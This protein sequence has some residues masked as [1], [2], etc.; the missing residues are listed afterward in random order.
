MTI[1]YNVGHNDKK[2]KAG[3]YTAYAGFSE[4]PHKGADNKFYKKGED[5]L[6][7]VSST[8][9]G[10]YNKLTTKVWY[11]SENMKIPSIETIGLNLAGYCASDIDTWKEI[12]PLKK[13]SELLCLSD[14]ANA[15]SFQVNAVKNL[16]KK[17]NKAMTVEANWE[18]NRYNLT[19]NYNYATTKPTGGATTIAKDGNSATWVGFFTYDGKIK[20]VFN[21]DKIKRNG[22]IF[23]GWYIGNTQFWNVNGEPT[24]PLNYNNKPW[25]DKNG[26]YKW[27]GNTNV[28]AKWTPIEWT[29]KYDANGGTGTMADSKHTY[30]DTTKKLSKCTFTK[31]GH[32]FE[33]WYASRARK[34]ANGNVVK[35]N[36][37]IVYEWLYC[38]KE[39]KY[40]NGANWFTEAEGTEKGYKKF[41]FT[42]EHTCSTITYRSNDVITMHAHWK[43]NT[44]TVK[45]NANGGTGTM[46]DS[47]HTYGDATKTLRKC[48]FTRK[49]YTFNGYWYA[50]RARRDANGNVVKANGKT[51]YEWLYGNKEGKY[52]NGANWFTA[53]EGTKNG[54]K[55]FKF[56]DGGTCSV[57][58]YRANDVI[59]MHAQWTP[60]KYNLTLYYNNATTKPTGGATTIAKDGKSATW[61]DYFTYDAKI[62][63]IFG[64][65]KIERTGY[66]F[67]GW[68]IGGKENGTKFWDAAGNP[69]VPLDYKEKP[70]SDKD[71]NYKWDGNT[72]VT[73]EWTENSYTIKFDGNKPGTAS[74]EVTKI[75][76]SKKVKY[77]E[78]VTLNEKSS[79]TGWTFTGWNTEA[80]GSG[81]GYKYNDVVSKLSATNNA[82]VTLY[83]QWEENSYNIVFHGNTPVKP[84]A[85]SSNVTGTVASMKNVKYETIFNLPK[86]TGTKSAF[87][88]TGWKF[89]GW[90]R[91]DTDKNGNNNGLSIDY[92]DGAE[93]QGLSATNGATVN[94][95]A[96]WD[97]NK[98]RI[99]LEKMAGE[100]GTDF[101]Y[102]KYD[103]GFYS[104][105]NCKNKIEGKKIKV[106]SRVNYKFNGYFTEKNSAGTAVIDTDGNI[107]CSDNFFPDKIDIND[108]KPHYEDTTS[109][110]YASWIPATYKIT[111]DDNGGKGGSGA[112]YEW[113]NT[114]YYADK[115]LNIVNDRS[116]LLIESSFLVCV[117][118]IHLYCVSS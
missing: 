47:K 56:P 21:K 40:E 67:N 113:F 20:N 103:T 63:K 101:F 117:N 114:G 78:K 7:Y 13:A 14:K 95:Y 51:V 18:A 52:V 66:T 32:T 41:K 70:W 22:Y 79:L 97:A 44:W 93:V 118:K 50:S 26:N 5:N 42:D 81:K 45:Y 33:Y 36:G 55:L 15:I 30:D 102:E 17:G 62:K 82:T 60:K 109:T 73:A 24:V 83:A 39:G 2:N 96:Q 31:T 38:N 16:I 9:D 72:N 74:N 99:N 111:L 112:I 28:T 54:Y 115:N 37:K 19:L 11:G 53:A 23:N 90:S 3:N 48:T 89:A 29:I 49:G 58:T 86:V 57:C 98:Y 76:A 110:V 106:P 75:P 69:T 116:F 88:L 80:D 8:K 105:E 6:I 34:D 94:L 61:N 85:A 64:A 100:N 71:G 10:E 65:G 27:F 77:T 84:V 87:A 4:N 25:S 91:S 107:K 46:A 12:N 92:K 59:T 35:E 43:P 68:Y 1:N 104:D 108:G